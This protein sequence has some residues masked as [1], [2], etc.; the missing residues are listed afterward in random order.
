MKLCIHVPVNKFLSVEC[1]LAFVSCPSLQ[2]LVVSVQQYSCFVQSPVVF[3]AVHYLWWLAEKYRQDSDLSSD[4]DGLPTS[5]RHK[6]DVAVTSPPPPPPP[7]TSS[8]PASPVTLRSQ[9]GTIVSRGRCVCCT[10]NGL[11]CLS[12]CTLILYSIL[13]I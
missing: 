9:N 3:F 8:A 5:R 7:P 11:V 2:C 12:W 4:E 6:N 10:Q 1:V 13:G